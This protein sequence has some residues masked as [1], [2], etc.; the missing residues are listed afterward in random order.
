M[1][2]D[3]KATMTMTMTPSTRPEARAPPSPAVQAVE[4]TDKLVLGTADDGTTFE[5]LMRERNRVRCF[6]VLVLCRVWWLVSCRIIH[7]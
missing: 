3:K 7:S 5:E 4:S 2:R 6:V 1:P